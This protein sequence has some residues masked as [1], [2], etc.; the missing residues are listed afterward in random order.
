MPIIS[1]HIGKSFFLL[2]LLTTFFYWL[3]YTQQ[4]KASFSAC[5]VCAEKDSTPQR[6]EINYGN[7]ESYDKRDG[8]RD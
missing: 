3:Y 7:K 4:R 1:L 8:E 5:M 6:T 2:F